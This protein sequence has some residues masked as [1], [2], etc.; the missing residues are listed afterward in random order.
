MLS[1]YQQIVTQGDGNMIKYVIGGICGLML[2]M[3]GTAY[4]DD[5][6]TMIGKTIDGEAPV[7]LDN[8]KVDTAVIVDGRSYVPVRSL[9]EAEGKSVF[10][11]EGGIYLET[12]EVT[13]PEEPVKTVTDEV[14][15]D[16]TTPTTPVTVTPT[17]ANG[18]PEYVT[19]T[20]AQESK[21]LKIKHLE[22]RIASLNQTIAD[23]QDMYMRMST[24]EGKQK[25]L[26]NIESTK[27]ILAQVQAE[28]DELKAQ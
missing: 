19:A 25:A 22:Y 16:P 12:P 5:I 6:A 4:A 18:M 26:A 2:G 7:Y 27:A 17:P 15:E 20:Q 28:L 8:S 3:A 9:A 11:N 1:Y 13:T 23:Y 24:E 10:F 21:E 14:Y